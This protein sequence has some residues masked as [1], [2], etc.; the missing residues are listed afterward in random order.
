MKKAIMTILLMVSMAVLGFAQ[1][2]P[3]LTSD[4]KEVCIEQCSPQRYVLFFVSSEEYPVEKL[5]VIA[6]EK[7][8]GM[9]IDTLPNLFNEIVKKG[10]YIDGA[11]I[12]FPEIGKA[13]MTAKMAVDSN[14]QTVMLMSI[15]YYD[16]DDT[17]GE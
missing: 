10:S 15:R 9:T 2:V 13:M 7:R 17:S 6:D 16:I 14:G 12:Y 4:G 3:F 8:A 1:S 11:F 5:F